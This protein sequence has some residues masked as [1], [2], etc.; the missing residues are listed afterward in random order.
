MTSIGDEESDDVVSAEV[1][2]QVHDFTHSAAER[3]IR[4]EAI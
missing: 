1:E 4:K 2:K 3:G